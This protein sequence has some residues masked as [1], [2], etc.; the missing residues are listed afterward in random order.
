MA[1]GYEYWIVYLPEF[2]PDSVLLFVH[3]PAGSTKL[4]DYSGGRERV[5]GQPSFDSV[6]LATDWGRTRF[7]ESPHTVS[8][9]DGERYWQSRIAGYNSQFLGSRQ[10]G[11]RI[12]A[13]ESV[14]PARIARMKCA[15][16]AMRGSQRQLQDY[17]N[18]APSLLDD[19]IF[20]AL[21]D[22]IQQNSPTIR[23][24]SPLASEQFREYRDADFLGV[25]GL[26]EFSKELENFWPG[27]GPCWDALGILT[28]SIP[29]SLPIALLVEAKSHVQE[30]YGNGCQAGE[31]TR[32][33]IQTSLNAAKSWCGANAGSDYRSGL[34]ICKPHCPSLFLDATPEPSLLPCEPLFC[35]RSLP[36][37]DQGRMEDSPCGSQTRTWRHRRDI[38]GAGSISAWTA[39]RRRS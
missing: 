6:R 22:K 27:Y 25:L 32:G 38:G 34:S 36:A 8:G 11:G 19:A 15:G 16:R 14:S 23:W 39:G 29:G 17:V 21:P 24:V 7:E 33:L 13:R 10:K 30:I 3:N 9:P 26:G 35:R 4:R 1:F 5:L 2:N 28:T 37:N 20:S 31:T 12:Q 18:L